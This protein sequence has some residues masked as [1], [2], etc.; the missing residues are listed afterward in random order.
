MIPLDVSATW[1]RMLSVAAGACAAAGAPGPGTRVGSARAA[2]RADGPWLLL[3]DLSAARRA[4]REV[5]EPWLLGHAQPLLLV[6][7]LLTFAPL[8]DEVRLEPTALSLEVMPEGYR[9]APRPVL[10]LAPA[11][12][13]RPE[14]RREYVDAL[15]GLR[16]P[17]VSAG[18]A[19][20]AI[21]EF[22]LELMAAVAQLGDDAERAAFRDALDPGQR[23]LFDV[24]LPA[25]EAALLDDLAGARDEAAAL[26]L[27]ADALA[28]LHPD[29][30]PLRLYAALER[31]H[32][33]GRAERERTWFS[34]RTIEARLSAQGFPDAARPMPA[35]FAEQASSAAPLLP[36]ELQHLFE[37]TE[38]LRRD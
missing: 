2:R 11:G 10:L 30:H 1:T 36:G 21:R 4:E 28:S 20:W 35:Q 9:D 19:L 13:L 14:R 38:L 3:F 23:H 18:S 16:V 17:L 6:R 5:V 7:E 12:R 22:D 27:E 37:A 8:H 29:E 15:S 33:R 24:Q 31:V 32:N 25:V 26:G 34:G